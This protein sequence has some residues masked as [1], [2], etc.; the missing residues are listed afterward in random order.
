MTLNYLKSAAIGFCFK[1]LKNVF[2]TAVVNERT[3]FEPLEF[4]WAQLFKV[5]CTAKASHIFSTKNVGIFQILA[6]EILTKR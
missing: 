4:Y 6:F 1:G 3:V 2:E 5:S